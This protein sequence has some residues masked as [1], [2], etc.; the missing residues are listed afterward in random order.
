MSGTANVKP[1][2]SDAEWAR[3][4]QRRVESLENP[5]SQRAGDWVLST[6][7]RT[8]ALIAS[9]VNGGSTVLAMPPEGGAELDPDRVDLQSKIRFKARRT[10]AQS[11][12]GNAVTPIQW[13]TVD[14][15]EGEW[16]GSGTGLFSSVT[17]P[18][19]GPYLIIGKGAWVDATNGV[20]KLI[21]TVNGMGLD[22]HELWPSN[23]SIITNRTVEPFEL[24]AGDAVGL[25]AYAS[26]TTARNIGAPSADPN[27]FTS[28]SII[29]LGE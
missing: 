22:A 4:T 27:S 3:G 24:A 7:P 6:D 28:L 25:S 21:T 29:Y 23:N 2:R 26:G 13:D 20:R 8:G 11:I 10:T 19:D 15:A 18:V 1:P 12:P 14:W 9:N 17:V 16:G 5:T